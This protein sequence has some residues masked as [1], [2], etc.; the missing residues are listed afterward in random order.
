MGGGKQ[1]MRLLKI[2]LADTDYIALWS[3]I[4]LRAT[5]LEIILLIFHLKILVRSKNTGH[6]GTKSHGNNIN[7]RRKLT[8]LLIMFPRKKV[9]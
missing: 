2:A 6:R 4:N 1:L 3:R 8:S 9:D 7:G 5:L